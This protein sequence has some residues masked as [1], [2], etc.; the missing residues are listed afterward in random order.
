MLFFCVL[1]IDFFFERGVTY[2]V[3]YLVEVGDGLLYEKLSTKLELGE[4]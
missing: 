2:F 1:V 4:A 3:L